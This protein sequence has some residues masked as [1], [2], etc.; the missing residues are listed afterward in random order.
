MKYEVGS[1]FNTAPT[2]YVPPSHQVPSRHIKNPL[3]PGQSSAL[4]GLQQCQCLSCVQVK[5]LRSEQAT[6]QRSG[7]MKSGKLGRTHYST[8]SVGWLS[9]QL[10]D[11]RAKAKRRNS[12]DFAQSAKLILK[13][14]ACHHCKSLHVA[15]K[16]G[17]FPSPDSTNVSRSLI[18]MLVAARST[19][20][21]AALK[22]TALENFNRDQCGLCISDMHEM[23]AVFSRPLD[24]SFDS[25]SVLLNADFLEPPILN[26]SHLP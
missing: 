2:T 8:N 9:F 26:S 4:Q 16:L 3:H 12:M 15:A 10:E 19:Y 7:T 25:L 17:S 18:H 21:H 24:S 23:K 13:P 5:A 22:P 1:K 6:N 14:G 11:W 20:L